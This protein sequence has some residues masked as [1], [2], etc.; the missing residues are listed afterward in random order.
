MTPDRDDPSEEWGVLNPACARSRDGELFLFPRLV[1]K[2]NLSR[3]GRARVTFEDGRPVGVERLGTVLEPVELWERNA[4]AGGVEDPRITWIESLKTYLMTYAAYGPLGPRIG[5]AS[6][7]DLVMWRRLGPVSFDY[8]HA[9]Q[10]DLNLYSNK[11]ALLFPEIVTAPDGTPS[12]AMLHRPTWDLSW[13][14]PGEGELPP[15]GVGDPRGAIWVSFAPAEEAAID[16]NRLTRYGQHR[17]VATPEQPWEELKIGGGTPPVR[18]ED[19]WLLVYHGVAGSLVPGTDHQPG[20]V[21]SAGVMILDVSD[22][23]RV[24][25]RSATPLLEPATEGEKD[26]IV[27]NV[28]FPTAIDPLGDGSADIFYG[29]ADSRIGAAR[30]LPTA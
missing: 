13:I 6:S 8:D 22:V 15:E 2:G 24:V 26:G 16:L 12:F 28:V 27:P 4:R 1:A 21:Y 25:A 7:D 11:D 5:L 23:T 30:L 10:T 29:M 3:V 18:V 14:V 17:V 19:G 9:L 20:V